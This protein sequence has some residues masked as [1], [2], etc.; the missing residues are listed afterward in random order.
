M[1]PAKHF[2]AFAVFALCLVGAGCER[3][4]DQRV[5]A[6]NATSA[7]T[8]D[9]LAWLLAPHEGRG[10]LDRDI[11]HC[12]A[13]LRA[14]ANPKLALERLGWLFIAKAQESFDPGFYRL[15]EQCSLCLDAYEPGNLEA[16]LLRGH[17][18]QNQHRFSEAEPLAR[19]LVAKRA[20][21]FDYG[22]LGDVLMELGNLPEATDAYQRMIDLRPGP[23][24]YARGAHMRWLKGDLA[25]ATELMRAAAEASSPQD[26][27]TKAWV[28]SRLA[29]LHFQAGKTVEA[30]QACD[31]A[32]ALRPDYPPALLLRG[33]MLLAQAD[34]VAAIDALQ[35]AVRANPIPEYQWT[36]AEALR[37]A[38]REA[39][40]ARVESRLRQSG[41]ATDPRTLSL[42]LATRREE[43][44]LAVRLAEEE[45]QQRQDVFTHDTLAWALAAAGR[46]KEAQNHMT[47]ALAEGT[48]DARLYLHATVIAAKDGWHEEAG[49]WLVKAGA[50]APLL[51]PAEL[52]QLEAAAELIAPSKLASI[53][54][55]NTPS[56]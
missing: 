8:T 23:H 7:G 30:D 49:E 46:L 34:A 33:R 25:G 35:R 32:L 9:P 11:R 51:L 13:Q 4:Q 27:H 24:S 39:E 47:R 42:Y 40:A 45:F 15:A 2:T 16:M 5:E 48:E 28:H 38:G 31:A 17:A 56:R 10:R 22:L 44:E 36:F 54:A 20:L 43:A 12:Q 26:P 52:A 19:E 6:Q 53:P 55:A 41:L 21:P 18:L 29:G 3:Q 37:A 14:G 50:L 1:K